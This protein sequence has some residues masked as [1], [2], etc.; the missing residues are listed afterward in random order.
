MVCYVCWNY[1]C[2]VGY[3]VVLNG[4]DFFVCFVWCE[5]VGVVVGIVF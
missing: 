1:E 5:W 3:F 2:I 4:C